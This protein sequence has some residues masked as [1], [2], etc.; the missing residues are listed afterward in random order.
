MV[1]PFWKLMILVLF[2]ELLIRKV[3]GS[4]ANISISLHLNIKLFQQK[5]FADP[6]MA[7]FCFG[8]AIRHGHATVTLLLQTPFL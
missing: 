4:A 6:K 5:V 7:T 1:T 2:D 3:E 8:S